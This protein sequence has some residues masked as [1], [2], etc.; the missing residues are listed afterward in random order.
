MEVFSDLYSRCTS[1][2][3]RVAESAS[4]DNHNYII[5]NMKGTTMQS[6]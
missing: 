4:E 5:A 2:C 6:T 1:V 3:G